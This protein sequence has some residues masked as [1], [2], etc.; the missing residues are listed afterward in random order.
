MTEDDT[1]EFEPSANDGGGDGEGDSD[2]TPDPFADSEGGE[3]PDDPFAELGDDDGESD[4]FADIEGVEVEDDPFT[5]LSVGDGDPS[6]D[7]GPSDNTLFT[8]E[9][10]AALDD[11]AVWEQIDGDAD[12]AATVPDLDED[13]GESADGAVETGETVVKKRSYC[14]RCEH[15]SQPPEVSCGYP[16]SEIVE[17]V[18]TGRFRVRNCPIVERR[19]SRDISSIADGG[20]ATDPELAAGDDADTTGTTDTADSSTDD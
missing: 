16:N 5:D 6:T 7:F 9:D 18:D 20:G 2:G 3:A 15:F 4:P 14:E 1:E 8:D 10:G 17:L 19:Q 11:E 12:E 13:L